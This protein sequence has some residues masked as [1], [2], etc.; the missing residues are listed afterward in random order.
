VTASAGGGAQRLLGLFL[1][2]AAALAFMLVA[3]TQLLRGGYLRLTQPKLGFD[4]RGVY[5][6][7]LS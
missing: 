6:M 1:G 2:A 4:P 3:G 5:A 7:E